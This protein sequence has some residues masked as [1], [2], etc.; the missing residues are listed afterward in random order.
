[1]REVELVEFEGAAFA[2]YFVEVA[3]VLDEHLLKAGYLFLPA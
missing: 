3:A 1:V 2:G